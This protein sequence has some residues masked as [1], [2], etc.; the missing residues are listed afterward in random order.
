MQSSTCLVCKESDHSVTRCPTLVE[1]LK[2]GFFTGGPSQGSHSHE[3]DESLMPYLVSRI[4]NFT[5]DERQLI[6]KSESQSYTEVYMECSCS[7]LYSDLT[8]NMRVIKACQIWRA[9]GE[10]RYALK[11]KI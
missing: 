10:Y 2:E 7:P 8:P 11:I 5:S 1:P 4:K 3:D 9:I 6:K